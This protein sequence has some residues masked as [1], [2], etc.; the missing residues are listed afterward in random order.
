[1]ENTSEEPRKLDMAS[2]ALT[3]LTTKPHGN[4]SY[5]IP[6]DS[7]S[8]AALT[9][10]NFWISDD[11]P[12]MRGGNATYHWIVKSPETLN[13]HLTL[14]PDDTFEIHLAFPSLPAGEYE[15]LAGYGGMSRN[16]AIAS[17]LLGF[18][19]KVDGTAVIAEAAAK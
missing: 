18:D 10:Q 6:S 14:K 11:G 5:F 4:G 8:Y 7:P 19:V 12:R 1:M 2:L 17:N 3:L 9:R 13:R 16:P 15:F